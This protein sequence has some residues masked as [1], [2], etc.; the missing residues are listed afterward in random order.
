MHR[1]ST[2]T[3]CLAPVMIGSDLVAAFETSIH[4]LGL[5]KDRLTQDTPCARRGC[6]RGGLGGG[7]CECSALAAV[8]IHQRMQ[9]LPRLSPSDLHGG[10]TDVSI[11]QPCMPLLIAGHPF[12]ALK[13]IT[14]LHQTCA[15]H[16]LFASPPYLRHPFPVLFAL[17]VAWAEILCQHAK[18]ACKKRG[19]NLQLAIS[20]TGQRFL[21]SCVGV[22]AAAAVEF[23]PGAIARSRHFLCIARAV[24]VL[25]RRVYRSILLLS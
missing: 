10:S 25:C 14:K 4:S 8:Q 16:A 21:G 5:L 11:K 12:G 2:W 6:C 22:T 7:C 24:V 3:Q 17:G 1:Q 13:A 23:A 15:L 20:G 9:P 18:L 19:Q